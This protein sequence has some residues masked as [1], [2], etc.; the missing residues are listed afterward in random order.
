MRRTLRRVAVVI[1]VLLSPAV[2]VAALAVL[3]AVGYVLLPGIVLWQMARHPHK[4]EEAR[5]RQ[6]QEQAEVL[7][8][9]RFHL[10]AHG[11]ADTPANRARVLQGLA[12]PA[13]R[14]GQR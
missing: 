1:G 10:I 7:E 12:R 2:A 14:R 9:I 8:L 11:L 13:A 4:K 6:Q 3:P 5:R